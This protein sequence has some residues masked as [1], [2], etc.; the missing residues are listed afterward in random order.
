MD[1]HAPPPHTH[2]HTKKITAR[3]RYYIILKRLNRH[4]E[5]NQ[6]THVRVF[7]DFAAVKLVKV[8]SE[9]EKAKIH[10]GLGHEH[11]QKSS[12]HVL[13][14]QYRTTAR[15]GNAVNNHK[16]FCLSVCAISYTVQRITGNERPRVGNGSWPQKRNKRVHAKVMT[17]RAP[18]SPPDYHSDVWPLSDTPLAAV[19]A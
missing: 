11:C 3:K 9:A 15:D 8:H 1:T 7:R 2:T 16:S 13:C 18:I 12:N 5:K 10:I 19:N 6:G 4:G 17:A 14:L